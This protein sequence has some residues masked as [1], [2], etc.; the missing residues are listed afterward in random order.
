MFFRGGDPPEPPGHGLGLGSA[1]GAGVARDED[2]GWF[3]GYSSSGG[4]RQLKRLTGSLSGAS[5]GLLRAD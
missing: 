2:L 3:T 1:G 5:M 4:W